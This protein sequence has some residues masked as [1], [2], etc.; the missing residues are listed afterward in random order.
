MSPIIIKRIIIG[1]R[2]RI[3]IVE[4]KISKNLIMFYER[5][6]CPTDPIS[7]IRR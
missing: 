6:D 2:R 7:A 4:K 3:P 1:L 5:F